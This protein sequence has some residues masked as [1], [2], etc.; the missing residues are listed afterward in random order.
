MFR[1]M[2]VILLALIA[3]IFLLHS[4]IPYPVKSFFYALSLSVKSLI[5]FSLPVIIFMILFKTISQL[6]REATKIILFL[7]LGV[8]VSNFVST[9]IS[10]QIGSA[11]YHLDL[12]IASPEV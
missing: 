1:K 2:P 8:C 10:Y 11:I 4:F 6:S 9:M 3:I 5:I 12:S 7:L